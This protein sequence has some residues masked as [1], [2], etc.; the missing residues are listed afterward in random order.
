MVKNSVTFQLLNFVYNPKGRYLI[1]NSLIDS[2]PYTVDSV[3]SPNTQQLTFLRTVIKLI[4]KEAQ[5]RLI[6][7]CDFDSVVDKSVDKSIRCAKFT[8]ELCSFLLEEDLH[9]IWRYQNSKEHDYTFYSNSRIDMFLVDHAS[10]LLTQQTTIGYITWS[11]H[12]PISIMLSDGPNLSARPP[13]RL[14]VI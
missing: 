8:L 2:S 11:D 3:Y 14:N 9:D 1:L 7:A 5:G 13:W 12:A 10:L 6:I 4:N